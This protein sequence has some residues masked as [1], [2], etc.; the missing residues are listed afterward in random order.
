MDPYAIDIEACRARQPRLLDAIEPTGAELVLLSR[1]E[2]VQ[3]ATGAF[4]KMPFVPLAVLRRDGHTTLVVP[5]RKA[6]QPAAADEI[7]G[8]EAKWHSTNRDE[9]L[10]ASS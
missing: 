3:W 4:V 5:D 7:I 1:R 10:A 9:Q 2:S 6:E 8:Y